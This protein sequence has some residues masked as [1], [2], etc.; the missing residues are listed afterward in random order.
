MLRPRRE[1]RTE[2]QQHEALQ[3]DGETDA[4]TPHASTTTPT[5]SPLRMSASVINFTT[6][7]TSRLHE[8]IAQ[9]RLHA[10]TDQEAAD[11]VRLSD[12]VRL[13][14]IAVTDAL[15]LVARV[16]AAQDLGMIRDRQQHAKTS[17]ARRTSG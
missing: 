7:Q 6:R 5:A 3:V 4:P 17:S 12:A 15:T 9:A 11:L 14:H 13:G 2:T 10:R 1:G 8:N 16:R